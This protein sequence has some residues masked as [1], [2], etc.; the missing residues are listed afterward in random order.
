M[1]IKPKHSISGLLDRKGRRKEE[2]AMEE[3]QER[4]KRRW[5]LLFKALT[6]GSL[7]STSD[8]FSTRHG[9]LFQD[10]F[11]KSSLHPSPSFVSSLPS[12]HTLSVVSVLP[13]HDQIDSA[14]HVLVME[15]D[16][17]LSHVTI[18]ELEGF[19]NTGNI[20]PPSSSLRPLQSPPFRS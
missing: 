8:E 7:P 1:T 2:D 18:K 17:R 11:F 13:L 15:R 10:L 20:C 19:D 6:E 9:Q 5:Q 12:Q 4:A 14:S 3:R 16:E